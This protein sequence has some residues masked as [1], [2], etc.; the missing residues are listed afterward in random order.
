MIVGITGAAGYLGGRLIAYL[1]VQEWVERIIAFD[2]MPVESA[3]KVIAYPFDMTNARDTLTLASI[4]VEHGV[5]HLVHAAFQIQPI[6][7]DSA[8]MTLTNVL[9]SSR[10]FRAALGHVEHLTFISSVAV[11]GYGGHPSKLN[12]V[13][14][15]RPTTAYGRDKRAAE[16]SLRDLSVA[17]L[18]RTAILRF[19]AIAGPH[20][21]QR[22]P[23]RALTAQPFFVL[24]DGGHARTQAVHEDDAA[25]LIAVAVREGASG[26]FNAAPDDIAAWSDIAQLSRRP[27]LALPRMALNGAT[28][29]NRTLPA[30]EGFTRDVVDLFSKTLTVGNLAIKSALGWQPRYGTCDAFYEMFKAQGTAR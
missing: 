30:L 24:A 2:K 11:Y 6:S 7:D 4:L 23:L 8:G 9:G 22:S 10:V 26:I 27:V 12:E 20:G 29:L 21:A 1:G 14:A 15:L 13:A 3:P 17:G 18:P 25:A 5:T 19:A 16:N 28:L